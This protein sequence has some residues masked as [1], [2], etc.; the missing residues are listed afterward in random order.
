MPFIDA[1]TRGDNRRD[2]N[3]GRRGESELYANLSDKDDL[4]EGVIRRESDRKVTDGD[5]E[6]GRSGPA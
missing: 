3:T 2:R 5:F 4:V 6:K 1:G